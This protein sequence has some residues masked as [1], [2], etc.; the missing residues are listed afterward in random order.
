VRLLLGTSPFGTLRGQ[1][2]LYPALVVQPVLS[3]IDSSVAP[4]DLLSEVPSLHC[5]GYRS[6]FKHISFG[7]VTRIH[8]AGTRRCGWS[9]VV[10]GRCS[11]LQYVAICVDLNLSRTRGDWS[12][13]IIEGPKAVSPDHEFKV[14][15]NQLPQSYCVVETFE[16]GL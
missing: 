7:D 1:Q 10:I 6:Q 16:A 13:I 14:E 12:F 4:Q 2:A 15:C 3:T 9:C 5:D 8:L 11:G